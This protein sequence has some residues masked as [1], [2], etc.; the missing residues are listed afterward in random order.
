M[1]WYV[2]CQCACFCDGAMRLS[3]AMATLYGKT[4]VLFVAHEINLRFYV[5]HT[6]SDKNQTMS[7]LITSDLFSNT[8]ADLKYITISYINAS[9]LTR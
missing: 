1:Y 4:L 7:Q 6:Y 9:R 5:A 3:S 2:V 8:R